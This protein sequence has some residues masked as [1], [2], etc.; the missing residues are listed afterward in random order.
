MTGMTI[1]MLSVLHMLVV[2]VVFVVLCIP[3]VTT[4]NESQS[5]S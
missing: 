5:Q 2:M 1:L 3:Q 4:Q